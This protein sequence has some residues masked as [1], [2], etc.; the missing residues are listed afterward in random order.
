MALNIFLK[1]LFLPLDGTEHFFK[2][3][4]VPLDGTKHLFKFFFCR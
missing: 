1:L 3:I 2:I 4:F